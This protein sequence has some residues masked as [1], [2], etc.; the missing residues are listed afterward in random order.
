MQEETRRSRRSQAAPQLAKAKTPLGKN[1]LFKDFLREIGKSKARFFSIFFIVLIGVGFFAGIKATAPDMEYTADKYFDESNMWDIHVMSTMGLTDDDIA[2]IAAVPGVERVQAGSFTDACVMIGDSTLT[3]FNVLSLPEECMGN[4]DA[5]VLDKINLVEGRMPENATECLIEESLQLNSGYELGDTIHLD[6]GTDT[7]LTEEVL[8]RDEYTIVGKCTSAI[9]MSYERG[10]SDIG[11][12]SVNFFMY[13]PEENFLYPVYTEAMITVSGAKD[14]STYSDAYKALVDNVQNEIENIGTDRCVIRADEIRAMY[15]EYLGEARQELND[16]QSEMDSSMAEAEKQLTDAKSQLDK[17]EAELSVQKENF[18][19]QVD[20]AAQTINEN[21]STLA[22]SYNSYNSAKST[23]EDSLSKAKDTLTQVNSLVTAAQDLKSQAQSQMSEAQSKMN[24]DSLSDS[25][26]QQWSQIY[27]AYSSLLDLTGDTV[28]NAGDLNSM[29]QEMM[30]ATSESLAQTKAELD[31]SSAKLNAGRLELADSEVVY[32]AVFAQNEQLLADGWNE[33]TQGKFQYDLQRASGEA[34]IADGQEQLFR[35]EAEMDQ[36][37][38]PIWYVLDRETNIGYVDYRMSADRIDAIAKIFPVF[39]FL[40]AALVC[41][42]TMTRMV[43]EQRLVIGTYKALGFTNSAISFK[44][45]AYAAIASLAGGII[46]LFL[47]IYFFPQTIFASWQLMYQIPDLSMILQPTLMVIS[48][49]AGVLVTVLSAYFVCRRDLQENPAMLMRPKAPKLGKAILLERWK[50]FWSH[51]SFSQKV[52]TR[53]L[54]RYKKRFWM[55]VIGITG[56]SALLIAGFGLNDSVK[57]VVTNQFND[58]FHY[59]MQIV[60]D[61]SISDEQMEEIK[62]VL[63]NDSTVTSY[64]TVGNYGVT[65]TAEDDSTNVMEA[66]MVVPNSVAALPDF[67]TIRD[68]ATKTEYKL[69][70]SGVVLTEQ[71]AKF[72]GVSVGDFIRIADYDGLVKRVEVTG[73]TEQY[74]YHYCYM[75]PA[76]YED[77]FH[78]KPVYNSLMVNLVSGFTE[79]ATDALNNKLVALDQVTSVDYYSTM[80]AEIEDSMSAMNGIIWLIIASAAMLAFVVL[81]NL[82]NINISERLREIAT[83]KVLGFFNGEV[84]VYVYRENIILSLIGAFAGLGVGVILHRIIMNTIEQDFVMFGYYISPYSFV[85]AVVITMFFSFLVGV[86]MY[87][88]LHNIQMV[89][90]LKS[91]E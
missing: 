86:V 82:T 49:L 37:T 23:Y 13:V 15:E 90:S 26:K 3:V 47:G 31:S 54:F 89:E 4:P 1:S 69:P 51:L 65:L 55:T 29:A 48:V 36:L 21:Q 58:I 59:T 67:I 81:Y 77:I 7:P 16:G 78:G 18:K 25:E 5:D 42:T 38:T 35:A 43:D 44:F 70:G 56:C 60:T 52:T 27:S 22:Q 88:R 80:A 83:I 10:S 64:D 17:G 41:S 30:E 14:L 71:L 73:I 76:V 53:N 34:Q 57:Q 72:L 33:Y 79:Q 24:D 9:F 85:F 61:Y 28:D 11:T 12:G 45:V 20:T 2:A 46:G 40:V 8:A 68:R 87:K 75:D 63:N 84:V 6:S 91:I 62:G 39:F 50:G 74:V 66:T 32:A 19:T